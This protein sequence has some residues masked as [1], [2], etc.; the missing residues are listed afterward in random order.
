MTR[1]EN[2]QRPHK[3]ITS[4]YLSDNRY[5]WD[6]LNVPMYTYAVL[7][8]AGPSHKRTHS[9]FG[10]YCVT[11]NFAPLPSAGTIWMQEILPLLLNGGDL[12]PIQTIP[13]WDRVPWLEEKRLA[14]VVDQLPSPRAMVSHFPYQLMPPSFRTS[15]AKVSAWRLCEITVC[16]TIF[17]ASISSAAFNYK[18]S[19]TEE[20]TQN[21]SFLSHLGTSVSKLLWYYLWIMDS[22]SLCFCGNQIG[23]C[24]C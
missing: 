21:Q 7:I 17:F 15:K 24:F 2:H 13:N 23:F 1:D 11:L 3:T 16:A 14:L 10:P 22:L 19:N 4:Q 6:I 20:K 12:T 8:P 5:Y 18:S 9:W